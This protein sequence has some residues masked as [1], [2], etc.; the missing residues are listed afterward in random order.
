MRAVCEDLHSRVP[1]NMV[2]KAS[3]MAAL[4]SLLE[5]HYS[6]SREVERES[7][8]LTL[9]RHHGSTCSSILMPL[10]PP[11]TVKHNQDNPCLLEIRAFRRIMTSMNICRSVCL[12]SV[13]FCLS[14][15]LSYCWRAG[16]KST[17]CCYKIIETTSSFHE[18]LI[19][20]WKHLCGKNA[21]VEE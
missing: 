12:C 14:F 11:Q 20:T 3:S 7:S 5:Y 9:L 1:D 16:N 4:Q 19:N 15:C 8:A 18:C 17:K 6:F 10:H 21:D 2:E 13:L